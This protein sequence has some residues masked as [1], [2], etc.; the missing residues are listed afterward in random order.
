MERILKEQMIHMELIDKKLIEKQ[1][2]CS[3]IMQLWS[4]PI[5]TKNSWIIAYNFM[6]LYKIVA[7]NVWR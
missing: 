7:H 2:L 5:D 4:S 3:H 6:G 1:K